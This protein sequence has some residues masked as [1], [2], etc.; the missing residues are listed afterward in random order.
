MKKI[1]IAMW[2]G[3]RNISTAMM[4]SFENRKDTSVID[5]PFYAYYLKN[6]GFNHPM[7][8]EI[9][10]SQ[11]TSWN[12]VASLC[13]GDIPNDSYIWYQKHMAHHILE[14]SDL[15]WLKNVKNCI[16]I[17]NPK[18][19]INSY[20]KKYNVNDIR[21]LGYI[22]QI[23]IFNY[24]K[25]KSYENPVIIDANDILD[26]P[27]KMLN[28]LCI[29][30]NIQFSDQMLT[31]PSGSRETDGVWAPYWYENVFKSTGFI[32]Y[33]KKKINL[34]NDLLFF[35]DECMKYYTFLYDKRLKL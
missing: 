15:R 7:R 10:K 23:E 28:K 30:M 33:K 35:Y 11:H 29:K 32:K 4:R 12:K 14:C 13:S 1:R 5:E 8:D 22:Q 27:K 2:S 17:R 26:N 21:Q 20:S 6:K 9:L 3:P 24:L 31:W 19:V 25:N 34:N 16:L 18:D